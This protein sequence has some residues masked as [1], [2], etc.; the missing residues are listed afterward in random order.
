MKVKYLLLFLLTFLL[1][2]LVG[3]NSFKSIKNNMED[4]GYTYNEVT[5]NEVK[6]LLAEFEEK[7]ITLP[8]FLQGL[9]FPIILNL[10]YKWDEWA[11]RRIW[12]TKR[13][14]KRFNEKRICER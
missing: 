2:T 13:I 11:T 5:S 12:N 3:C 6:E 10:I 1:F 7:D 14:H 9:N 8:Y 4:A